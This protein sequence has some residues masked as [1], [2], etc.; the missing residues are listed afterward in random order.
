MGS[1]PTGDTTSRALKEEG[2]QHVQVAQ[3]WQTRQTQTLVFEGSTPSL[4]TINKLV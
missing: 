4:G 2:A 1:N 3:S